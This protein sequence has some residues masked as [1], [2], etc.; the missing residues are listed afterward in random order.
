VAYTL[1]LVLA[2]SQHDALAGVSVV[3]LYFVIPFTAVTMIV[4]A[5]REIRSRSKN[6]SE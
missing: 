2:T 3:M 1:Y 4:I 6:L 5:L